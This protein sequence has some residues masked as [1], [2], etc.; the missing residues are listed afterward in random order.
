MEITFYPI[1]FDLDEMND[2]FDICFTMICGWDEKRMM[3][4]RK[5]K[6]RINK[7]RFHRIWRWAWKVLISISFN[8]MKEK[9]YLLTIDLDPLNNHEDIILSHS[10]YSIELRLIIK[11][12]Y[13]KQKTHKN[14]ELGSRFMSASSHPQS[15]TQIIS[16]PFN[17]KPT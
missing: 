7:N 11:K 1:S 14:L 4:V 16:S 3:K 6:H 8:E 5:I 2:A 10:Y 12:N 15:P 9:I 13:H 17:C